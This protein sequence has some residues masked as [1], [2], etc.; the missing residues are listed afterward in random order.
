MFKYT[1][2]KDIYYSIMIK[3]IL[4]I[5][6]GIFILS[7]FV[8]AVPQLTI[9]SPTAT[10]YNSTK[11]LLNVTSNEPVDFF[12]KDPRGK[13]DLILGENE[14]EFNNYLYVNEGEHEFTIWANNSN[15]EINASVFYNTTEHNPVE[16]TSCGILSSSDTEYY[17]TQNLSGSYSDFLR[18]IR[19]WNGRN[20]SIDLNGYTVYSGERGGIDLGFV[21]D[22]KL[23]NGTITGSPVTTKE[24]YYIPI[25]L[26]LDGSRMHIYN[27][28]LNGYNGINLWSSN[29][30]I[31]ENVSINSSIGIHYESVKEIYV[32]NSELIWNG[33]SSKAALWDESYGHAELILQESNI[34]DFPYEFWLDSIFSDYFLRS[35]KINFSKIK[36][37]EFTDWMS[38]TRF[39]TQHLILIDVENQINETGSGVVEILDIG[40][41]PRFTG[42]DSLFETI[43]NPTSNLL[44][45]TNRDG[46][47]EVWLTEKLTYAKTSSPLEI[48]EYEFSPYNLT[49][50]S[51]DSNTTLELDL[52]NVNS[53]IPVSIQIE[54]PQQL[55]QC[56]IPQ[57][58]DLNNDG[59]VNNQDALIVIRYMTGRDVSFNSTKGCEGININPF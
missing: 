46:K 8:S 40:E 3:K 4:L 47:A 43:S 21:S 19:L 51:W 37:S 55:S 26:D 59:T 11:I 50:R 33:I 6:L 15:G 57:M 44:I 39:F 1:I 20:I 30:I 10:E 17:V 18:C 36:P 28:K 29:N 5:F 16:I 52:R 7:G 32:I 24:Y 58:L 56:T 38:D 42:Y 12:I 9:N 34:T 22:V 27:L 53:T 48:T 54:V 25:M 45:A 2:L 35:T 31:I 13:R 41:V 49:G 23:F 14:T